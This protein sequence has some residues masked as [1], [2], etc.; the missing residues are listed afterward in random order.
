MNALDGKIA[1]VTGAGRGVGR[2]TALRLSRAGA[3]VVV[4]DL[5]PEPAA[6]AAG[7]ITAAGGAALAFPG[8]VTEADFGDRLAVA[9]LA[10]FGDLHIVVNNAGYIWNTSAFNHTDE[11][12]QAMLD[13]HAT[14]PFRVLRAA[15]RHFRDAAKRAGEANPC[16]KVVNVSSISGHY[17]AALQ[18]GYAAGKAALIGVTRALANSKNLSSNN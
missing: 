7:E 18:L 13:V 10:E 12:F 15:G 4:N 14:A 17:G 6:A 1:I 11:Q 16:R 3:R 8:D 5:D 9:A 2:A